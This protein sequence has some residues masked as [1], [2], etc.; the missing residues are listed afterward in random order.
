MPLGATR[1]RRSAGSRCWPVASP[2]ISRWA[3]SSRGVAGG[4]S[5]RLTLVTRSL[6]NQALLKCFSMRF[7]GTALSAPAVRSINSWQL[8]LGR[9]RSC[10]SCYCRNQASSGCRLSARISRFGSF[11]IFSSAG[12]SASRHRLNRGSYRC[13][14]ACAFLA[15]LYLTY[16]GSGTMLVGIGD[17]HVRRSFAQALSR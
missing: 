6:R 2:K 4:W 8:L 1:L 10:F 12:T 13:G 11:S 5:Y 7:A 14:N 17:S 9:W 16:H 3:A 15:L